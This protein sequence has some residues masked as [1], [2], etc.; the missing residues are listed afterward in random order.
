MQG[1]KNQVVQI[2]GLKHTPIK[3]LCFYVKTLMLVSP[4]LLRSKSSTKPLRGTRKTRFIIP[5]NAPRAIIT[6]KGVARDSF[7]NNSESCIHLFAFVFIFCIV[8]FLLYL[9]NQMVNTQ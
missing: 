6:Y 1:E 8:V 5:T 7:T 4:E 2:A 3:L 9:V